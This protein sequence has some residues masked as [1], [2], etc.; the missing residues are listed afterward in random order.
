M[1]FDD[2]AR[3]AGDMLAITPH[4]VL[5]S[6]LLL[7]HDRAVDGSGADVAE[8]VYEQMARLGVPVPDEEV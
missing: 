6:A 8:T 4:A 5:V 3:S 2:T 1:P 7:I